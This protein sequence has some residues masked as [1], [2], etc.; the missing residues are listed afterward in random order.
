MG[1]AVGIDTEVG[2]NMAPSSSM[3]RAKDT[4]AA[5]RDSEFYMYL[6]KI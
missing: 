3:D 1:K 2:E 5:E 6:R 4:F